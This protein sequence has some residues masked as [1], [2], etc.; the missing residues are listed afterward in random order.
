MSE[1]EAKFYKVEIEESGWVELIRTKSPFSN[2]VSKYTMWI[3][4]SNFGPYNDGDVEIKIFTYGELIDIQLGN[5][6]LPHT[7]KGS[8]HWPGSFSS[9]SFDISVHS[10]DL[11]QDR[12]FRIYHRTQRVDGR[13]SLV[14]G[15]HNYS[16]MKTYCKILF[17]NLLKISYCKSLYFIDHC[18]TVYSVYEELVVNKNNYINYFQLQNKIFDALKIVPDL[19]RLY[20]FF[21]IRMRND[22][23]EKCK[24]LYKLS[25]N[26]FNNI[27]DYKKSFMLLKR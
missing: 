19:E 4:Y 16:N 15:N 11:K 20:Y 6:I 22:I 27:D 1:W 5:Y 3:Q 2:T 25:T 7:Y 21:D 23:V 10:Q 9:L 13:Y 12:T 14:F 8:V 17:E 18:L 24:I 26:T